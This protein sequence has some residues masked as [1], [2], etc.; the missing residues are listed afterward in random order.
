M[1][2]SARGRPPL[3]PSNKSNIPPPPPPVSAAFAFDGEVDEVFLDEKPGRTAAA[4]GKS[5]RVLNGAGNGFGWGSAEDSGAGPVQSSASI[6]YG[7]KAEGLTL[8]QR[9]A[10]LEFSDD[11]DCDED[12]P[13]GLGKGKA[14]ETKKEEDPAPA[15]VAEE[16]PKSQVT[17]EVC[18]AFV[19]E[20]CSDDE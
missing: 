15:S 10:Q 8:N 16:E 9:L 3:M 20:A 13:L 17:V 14:E 6:R 4:A 18:E 2:D 1:P 7:D 12:D 11:E 19:Q 5:P